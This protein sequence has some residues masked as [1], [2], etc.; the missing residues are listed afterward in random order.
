MSSVDISVDFGARLGAS[1]RDFGRFAGEARDVIEGARFRWQEDLLEVWPV[2]TGTSL[3]AWEN[4]TDGLR[5][6]LRN[7]V[8]YVSH[9]FTAGDSSRTPIADYL[10]A[11]AETYAL[12]V[13]QE[14]RGL[15]S[16]ALAESRTRQ[17]PLL[18]RRQ[19]PSVG[20]VISQAVF[21]ASVQAFQ[22][23]GARQRLRDRFPNEPIGRAATRRRARV[24]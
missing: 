14:L 24:R 18:G 4:Y 22:V 6:V 11:Q 19:P 12:D 9:V 5:W 13:A 1:M 17:V 8:E 21:A 3:Q 15:L 2:D 23:R 7:P 20:Q 10:E 16:R